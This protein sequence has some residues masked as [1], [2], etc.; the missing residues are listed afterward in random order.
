ML[1]A[2]RHFC[3]HWHACIY[4][5]KLWVDACAELFG[6]LDMCAV[7]AIRAQD[8]SEYIIEVSHIEVIF[9]K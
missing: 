5:F 9:L 8:G 1:S 2:L 7:K 3:A 6:G 4:R